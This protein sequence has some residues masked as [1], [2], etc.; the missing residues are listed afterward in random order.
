[1]QLPCR[2]LR[3]PRRVLRHGPA[4]SCSATMALRTRCLS[5][6]WPGMPPWLPPLPR[7]PRQFGFDQGLCSVPSCPVNV[8]KVSRGRRAA[9][10]G[11]HLQPSQA[12]LAHPS[13]FAPAACNAATWR[14]RADGCISPCDPRY[15]ASRVAWH[16]DL[17]S[18]KLR[19]PRPC[20]IPAGCPGL[21]GLVGMAPD[22]PPYGGP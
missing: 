21:P 13:R 1:M 16:L 7:S 5:T 18:R 10:S 20:R 12:G 8:P 3:R 2:R 22:R 17:A 11:C 14:I 9:A 6:E 19:L 4:A 15:L